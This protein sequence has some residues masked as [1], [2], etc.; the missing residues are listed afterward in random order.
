M[1]KNTIGI[2][3][4][5]ISANLVYAQTDA[6][7][8]FVQ[9]LSWEQVKE[10]AKTENKYIFLDCYASWCGPCKAMDKEV[11]PKETVG[12]YMDH[13][14]I[15][16]KAQMDTSKQDDDQIKQFYADAHFLMKKY[17]INEFPYLLFFS[18]EG[19]IVHKAVGFKDERSLISISK[20]AQDPDKQ[21][22]TLVEKYKEH[23]LDTSYMKVLAQEA[24]SLGNKELAGKIANDY[25]NR[26]SENQLYKLENIWFMVDFTTSTMDR[27]FAVFRDHPDKICQ[28]DSTITI[29]GLKGF[30]KDIIYKEE[31]KPYV[32][33]KNGK[34]DWTIM[35]TNMKKYGMLGNEAFKTYKPHILFKTEIEPALIIDPDWEKTLVLIKK[36]NAGKGEEF[37]VG[38]TIVYYLNNR[39]GSSNSEECKN[40]MASAIYYFKNYYSYL[41]SDPLN[42]WAWTVFQRSKEK[43]DLERA[44][45][46]SDSSLKL[47]PKPN[48][49]Y[50]DTYSNLL[51]KLGR[52][53]EALIYEEKAA[54]LAPGDKD[55]QNNFLKMKKGEQTWVVPDEKKDQNQ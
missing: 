32:S 41:T 15:S 2:I 50:L 48:A 29:A 39:L 35:K 55:I 51:Y 42:T 28:A 44:L 25:I 11:Y 49:G 12:N 21:F 26:L 19:K 45:V 1:K 40:F 20:D 24:N 34:P 5:F 52:S 18:P 33:S 43:N 46:W 23:I 27:G 53:G 13:H 31:M 14:F 47:S 30:V 7:V 54:T 10:K 16:I 36:Q 4:Y 3:L 8:H 17:K 22:C 9:G 38:S 37:L 6:G